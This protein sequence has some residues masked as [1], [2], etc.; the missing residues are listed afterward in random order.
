MKPYVAIVS[1]KFIRLVEMVSPLQAIAAVTIAPFIVSRDPLEPPLEAHEGTHILQQYE[2]GVGVAAMTIPLLMLFGAPWWMFLLV[3]LAGFMPIFGGFYLLYWSQWFYWYLRSFR[4]EYPGLT[5]GEM[6]YYLTSFER[7]AQFAETQTNYIKVRT[8][9][10]WLHI[11]ET[12][13][14]KNAYPFSKHLYDWMNS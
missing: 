5:P 11:A 9:F 4:K 7:E 6:A 2:C 1:P 14:A 3:V 13:E 12:E 10:A 8:W